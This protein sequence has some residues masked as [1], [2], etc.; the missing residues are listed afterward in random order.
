MQVCTGQGRGISTCVTLKSE[1]ARYFLSDQGVNPS[2]NA[3]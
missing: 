1:H 2:L 3:S